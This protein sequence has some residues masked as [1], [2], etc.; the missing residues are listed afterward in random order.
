MATAE[1]DVGALRTKIEEAN[2]KFKTVE[3]KF[4]HYYYDDIENADHFSMVGEALPKAFQDIFSLY[5][6][7]S[8]QEYEQQ[9]LKADNYVEYLIQK[10]KMIYELYALEIDYRVDDFMYIQ[11]AI[12]KNKKFEQYKDLSKLA[13]KKLPKTILGDYFRGL[14]FEKVGKPKKAMRS[15]QNAYGLREVGGI[16]NDLVLDKAETIKETFGY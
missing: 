6:S 11:K 16:T 10:Y 3:N 4:F 12:E 13:K 8:K 14:Y 9:V 5:K 7:I 2:G 1:K 15:Y